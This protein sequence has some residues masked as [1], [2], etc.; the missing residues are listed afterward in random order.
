MGMLLRI[1]F[2]QP[3]C[4]K[5]EKSEAFMRVKRNFL[6]SHRLVEAELDLDICSPD[7]SLMSFLVTL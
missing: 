4:F 1:H 6:V 2:V 3:L 5:V 7:S